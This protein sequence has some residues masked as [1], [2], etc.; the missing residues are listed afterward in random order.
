M[1]NLSLVINAVLA[2]AIGI[3]FF[4]HFRDCKTVASKTSTSTISP[5]GTPGSVIA[6]V[7]LDS[8]ES[9]YTYYRD[10]KT[11][12]EREQKNLEATLTSGM[13]SLQREAYQFE[14]KAQTM[15]QAEGEATQQRL[16]AKKNQLEQLRDNGAQNLQNEMTQ[17]NVEVYGKIDSVLQDYNKDHKYAYVLSYQRGGAILY[18]DKGLDI[19]ND[20]VGL[21]NKL[22]N[23]SKK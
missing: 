8:L 9:N 2:I 15:S 23:T 11:S 3:L 1:K 14:Q 10:R 13:E 16:T 19:T 5:S 22:N 4:L 18:R 17:F 20:V 7:D 12:F 6:Y 21:L